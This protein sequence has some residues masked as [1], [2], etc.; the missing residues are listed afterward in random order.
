MNKNLIKFEDLEWNKPK[1]GVGQKIY[2]DGK[3]RIRLLRFNEGFIEED[4]CT[5]G[6][7]GY[8]LDGE[9]RIDFNGEIKKY[10]KGDGLWI[11]KGE[12]SRHKVMIEKG[13]QIE[14]V[15]FESEK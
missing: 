5:K 6:H 9:M 7:I 10:S 15:L 4:W 13:K 3:I 11:I 12:N 8:V 14:L 2:T 1:E